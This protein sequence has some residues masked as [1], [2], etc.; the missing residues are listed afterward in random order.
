MQIWVFDFEHIAFRYTV[1]PFCRLNFSHWPSN[2]I[3]ISGGFWKQMNSFICTMLCVCLW[4]WLWLQVSKEGSAWSF[5]ILKGY[6]KFDK[7]TMILTTSGTDWMHSHWSYFTA[8]IYFFGNLNASEHVNK[9][10]LFGYH[11]SSFVG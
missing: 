7:D 10:A 8:C 6:E 5:K 1:M 9:C 4:V 2:R 3:A 11:L